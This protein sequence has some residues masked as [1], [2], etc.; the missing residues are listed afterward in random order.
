V[1]LVSVGEKTLPLP[2]E[3]FLLDNISMKDPTYNSGAANIFREQSSLDEDRLEIL[4]ELHA[5]LE[6]QFP[7]EFERYLELFYRYF[8]KT[9]Y[10]YRRSY[11]TGFFESKGTYRTSA[12]GHSPGDTFSRGCH[13]GEIAK[14]LDLQQWELAKGK[15]HSY[16]YHWVGM[17][18]PK[19]SS[20]MAIDFDSKSTLLGFYRAGEKGKVRPVPLLTLDHLKNVKRIYDHF[21][22]AIWCISSATLGLHI[23]HRFAR[24]VPIDHIQGSTKA[25]L[26]QIGLGNIEV[27]PMRGRCFRRPF[28]QDYY[29]MSDDGLIADWT[30]QL[31]HFES[32]TASPTFDAIYQGLR[33]QMVA[34]WKNYEHWRWLGNLRGKS[35]KLIAAD[36]DFKKFFVSKKFINLSALNDHLQ[37]LDEWATAGFPVESVEAVREKPRP[38]AGAR[39]SPSF[40]ADPSDEMLA[41]NLS[42]VCRKGWVHTCREWAIDGLP[43]HDSIFLVVS[44]LARWLFYIE[45]WEMPE[46]LRINKISELL[47]TY[48]IN[49]HNGYV[50]RITS[51]LQSEVI[52]QVPR[53]IETAIANTDEVGQQHFSES[54]RKRTAGEYS[55]LIFLEPLLLTT[56]STEGDRK[57]VQHYKPNRKEKN[58]SSSSLAPR[59][60]HRAHASSWDYQP[61]DT[62]LPESIENCILEF[63]RNKQ[64]KIQK[65][66]ICKLR[67]VINDLYS[68]NGEARRSLKALKKM[69]F[70]NDRARQHIRNLETMGIIIIGGYYPAGGL[71]TR[72]TLTSSAKRFLDEERGGAYIE[73]N[74]VKVQKAVIS[75]LLFPS[76]RSN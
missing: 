18:A 8:P 34:E 46:N 16:D 21:P 37:I 42:E 51:G 76:T 26:H 73:P 67:R 25:A 64:L 28:G 3:G 38:S 36:P 1:G 59:T 71:G 6:E 4:R 47:T 22:T 13:V 70:S 31:D 62:P 2:R 45:L 55:E 69:G 49:K 60:Q 15:S 30:K 61:D 33:H 12:K 10:H 9:P 74:I 56:V 53:I 63:Y 72:Y 50:S 54:R 39:S 75:A 19:A 5:P 52:D 40:I 11:D 17:H 48:V 41:I 14:M 35:D 68:A 20:L 29:T 66:T 23:W 44:Q 65:R 7:A 57:R 27:H 58:N 32:A 43:C 24:P